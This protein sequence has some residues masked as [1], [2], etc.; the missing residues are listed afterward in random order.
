M[1]TT[2]SE[3]LERYLF[4]NRAHALAGVLTAL[5]GDLRELLENYVRL[6]GE[7]AIKAD[8]DDIGGNAVFRISFAAREIYDC[9]TVLK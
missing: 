3:N 8:M 1:K 4:G 6:D 2:I 5:R 9:G 7:I